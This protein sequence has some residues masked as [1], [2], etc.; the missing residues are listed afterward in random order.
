ML[1]NLEKVKSKNW[2]QLDDFEGILIG[3]SLK[4][5]PWKK[6]VKKFIDNNKGVLKSKKFGVF[7]C[8]VNAI[9]ESS[10]AK[11]DIAKRLIDNYN[12]KADIYEAFGGVLDFSESSK[13]GKIGKLA[14]KAAA[15]EIKNEKGIEFDMQGLND[16]RNW[17]KIRNFS[18][19]FAEKL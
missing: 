12:L 15:V 16:F 1:L 13:F 10:E 4:M 8:G 17:D 3:T 9:G 11:E 5:N 18:I 7:T 14:L 19:S 2:P 6:E